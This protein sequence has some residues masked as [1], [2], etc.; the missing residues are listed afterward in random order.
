VSG[1]PEIDRTGAALT[2]TA[3]RLSEQIERERSFAAQASHQLSTPL[4]RLRLELEGGLAGEPEG[5][6][7][8]A[9]EALAT[10]EALS[11]TVDEVL[12]LTRRATAPIEAFAVEPLVTE[13]VAQWRGEFA[14]ADRPLRL[15]VEDPPLASASPVAVRQILQV[16]LDNAHR[17]GS[18]AVTVTVRESGGTV[19]IDVVDRGSSQVGWPAFDATPRPLG[20]AMARSL[21]ESQGG[22]LLLNSDDSVTRFT[23]LVPADDP[24]DPPMAS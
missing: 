9:H 7:A 21:A 14:S 16:L 10:A 19:A 24:G 22:R 4:T 5:L 23:L 6:P 11:R 3:A 1:V 2:A 13:I 15:V 18:G 8:A 20:L 12:A 17:H